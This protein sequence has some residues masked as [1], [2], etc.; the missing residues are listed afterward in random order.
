MLIDVSMTWDWLGDFS[1]RVVIPIVLPTVAY[2][3]AATG[4]EL[5]DEVFAL[6]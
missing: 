4:F 3:D 1:G 6:H 5:P 2:Q